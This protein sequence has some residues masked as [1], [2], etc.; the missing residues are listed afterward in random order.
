MATA[1]ATFDRIRASLDALD[2]F[3]PPE[4]LIKDASEAS[5]M[6]VSAAAV[7]AQFKADRDMYVN[8]Q[9]LIKYIEFAKENKVPT[10]DPQARM[11]LNE[12][13]QQL[14]EQV[15]EITQDLTQARIV[16]EAKYESLMQKRADL[17]DTMHDMSARGILGS[18]SEQENVVPVDENEMEEE[19]RR[20]E[21]LQ[22]KATE[23]KATLAAKRRLNDQLSKSLQ[24]KEKLVN[25][26]D[27]SPLD[28]EA[29]LAALQKQNEAILEPHN[30]LKRARD[31][32]QTVF[33]IHQALFGIRILRVDAAPD[34][35]AADLIVN[36]QINGQHDIQ[37]GF[38]RVN[39]HSNVVSSANEA[40][41][42]SF[43][44]FLSDPVIRGPRLQVHNGNPF[45][46]TEI[47][48][49][50]DLVQVSQNISGSADAFEFLIIETMTRISTT[51]AIVAEM[52][53]LEQEMAGDGETSEY[54]FYTASSTFGDTEHN[55]P[56][57]WN[58]IVIMLKMATDC[59]KVNGGVSIEKML[60]KENSG[61]RQSELD[62]VRKEM[63]ELQFKRPVEL[64][65]AIKQQVSKLSKSSSTTDMDVE[66]GGNMEAM[67][68]NE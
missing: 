60:A 30:A 65:R 52:T 5:A 19:Q 35:V 1:S 27:G 12:Q 32:C 46:Q 18:V 22:L 25:L 26:G 66:G 3:K 31:L 36:L 38:V 9:T 6:N 11:Q 64:Y 15:K 62:A 61:W 63:N 24:E 39:S 2:Q 68:T 45:F 41:R 17:E 7:L 16:I 13:K 42:P 67:D 58:D 50:H 8:E 51:E 56:F 34:N 20:L 33:D 28:E 37:I 43:A 48:A 10:V 53:E 54:Q 44:T 29:Q 40:L 57:E 59:P 4:G 21:R 14:I 55:V 47:P 23:L 49:L